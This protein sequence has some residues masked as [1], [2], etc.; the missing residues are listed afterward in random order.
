VLGIQLFGTWR[1]VT[2]ESCALDDLQFND[3]D[4]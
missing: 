2:P 1:S 4:R 3:E